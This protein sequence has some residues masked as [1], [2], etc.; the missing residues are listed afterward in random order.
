LPLEPWFDFI[1]GINGHTIVRIH[2]VG[3]SIMT[4]L[5]QIYRKTRIRTCLR[6]NAGTALEQ[7]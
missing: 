1:V 7:A 2:C 4:P 6:Q 3:P 5:T